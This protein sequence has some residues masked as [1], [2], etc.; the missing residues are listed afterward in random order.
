MDGAAT[1]GLT[2][3]T[4]VRHSV[5]RIVDSIR[6][7][8]TQEKTKRPEKQ[9]RGGDPAAYKCLMCA[10]LARIIGYFH[11]RALARTRPCLAP[12]EPAAV[13]RGGAA[14]G[15]RAGAVSRQC[16]GA[17]LPCDGVE[18]GR[19]RHRRIAGREPAC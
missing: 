11:A 10:R 16:L 9:P 18:E 2:K 4:R 15:C 14:G 7:A 3:T 6:R 17:R 1:A 5:A 19:R 12:A 13:R 8:A